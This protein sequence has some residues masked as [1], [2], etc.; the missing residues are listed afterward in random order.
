VT[1]LD[2]ESKSMR[3]KET[4]FSEKLGTAPNST[5]CFSPAARAVE[6][7][8]MQSL[9]PPIEKILLMVEYHEQFLTYWGGGLYHGPSLKREIRKA[10]N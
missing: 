7:V 4:P 5:S 8:Q 6:T 10:S 1:L 3:P 2:Q 9:L